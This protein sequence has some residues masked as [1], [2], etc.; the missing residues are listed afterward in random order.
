[1]PLNT[2]TDIYT[3]QLTNYPKEITIGNNFLQNSK[4]PSKEIQS[5]DVKLIHKE[6]LKT[7]CISKDNLS[8]NQDFSSY[9]VAKLDFRGTLYVQNNC[10]CFGNGS[11]NVV[12]AI[13]KIQNVKNISS[14]ILDLTKNQMNAKKVQSIADS[15]AKCKNLNSLEI[16]V[17]QDYYSE[18]DIKNI[19]CFL[20]VCQ[21]LPSFNLRITG[22]ENEVS[23]N[24][25][26]NTIN[27]LLDQT[28]FKF[29][30][31]L[32]KERFT[33]IKAA[34]YN[35]T[36]QTQIKIKIDQSLGNREAN[37]VAQSL[38]NYQNITDLTLY[39]K[40]SKIG[41]EG[42]RSIANIIQNSKNTKQLS[43]YLSQDKDFHMGYQGANCIIDTVEKC[44]HLNLL[45]LRLNN[46]N[47]EVQG[48]KGVSNII[49]RYNSI[50]DLNAWFSKSRI[51]IEGTNITK[52]SS[53]QNGS[54]SIKFNI[55]LSNNIN[56][57]D[58]GASSI[59][60]SIINCQRLNQFTVKLKQLL[61]QHKHYLFIL[62]LII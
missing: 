52:N 30:E 59:F 7:V 29:I 62:T 3:R 34:L 60:E 37:N 57:D 50:T 38:A 36:I 8:H 24:K 11:N 16:S 35:M 32:H 45:N 2:F 6:Q 26:D 39:F 56:M 20:K 46:C 31:L 1:M 28:Q 55:N 19:M 43:L 42:A 49:Q 44:Q 13:Q 48:V 22:Q 40:N 25:Q 23:L 4:N 21:E 47:I 61:K 5:S 51:E 10:L 53:I 41:I 58:Q 27:L 18:T 15:L 14:L 33:N 9:Q 12:S 54:N 17:N